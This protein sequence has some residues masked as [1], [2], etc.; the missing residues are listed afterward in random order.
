MNDCAII[1]LFQVRFWPELRRRILPHSVA[2]FLFWPATS[3]LFAGI[4]LKEQPLTDSAPWKMVLLG[5]SAGA[6]RM[7]PEF[8]ACCFLLLTVSGLLFAALRSLGADRPAPSRMSLFGEPLIAMFAIFCGLTLEFPVLL[9]HPLVAV[10]RHMRTKTA[11]IALF[12]VLLLLA[13][14]ISFRGVRPRSATIIALMLLVVS[15]WL[16]ALAGTRISARD[17]SP[18]TTVLLALDSLSQLDDVSTL[19]T[20]TRRFSGTWYERVVTPGLLTNSVWPAILMHRPVRETGTFLIYQQVNWAA[21]PFNLVRRMSQQ[22]CHTISFFSDQFTIYVGSTGGF[23]ENRSGPRG[24]MQLATAVVKDASVFLPVVLN[25]LP[26]IPGAG[27]PSNQASTYA[28]DLRKEFRSILTSSSGGCT[29]SAAHLSYLHEQVY[30]RFSDLTPDEAAK[31]LTAPVDSLQD[32]SLDWQY[33]EIRS[34]ALG[35]YQW[36]IR[37][38]QRLLAEE[39]R[40]TGFLEPSKRNRLILFSDHG[41]RT[42][43]TE[44]NFID[45]RYHR[46]IFATLGVPARDPRTPISLLD[47]PNLLGFEDPDRPG[48]ADP[49]VEY[50]NGTPAEWT[51]LMGTAKLASDGDVI[52]DS[53]IVQG[54]GLRLRG[55]RP[56]APTPSQ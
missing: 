1:V 17:A 8:L 34:D 44:E 33:P 39:I 42:G 4:S 54:I 40:Q 55:Y 23:A 51:Y 28:F 38:L 35:V 6:L 21:S 53:R 12:P 27:T 46:V 2:I 5:A 18:N 47:I 48:P 52:L 14:L 10:L 19:R 49:V 22:D 7:A 13:A 11:I 9:R 32:L 16:L 29:F 24:W 50:A 26:R 15:G 30:P 36:K 20:M 31:I 41:N 25:K 37:H 45:P 56:Y 43:L 3:V